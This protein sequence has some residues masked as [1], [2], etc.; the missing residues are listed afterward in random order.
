MSSNTT[1]VQIAKA[2]IQTIMKNFYNSK[3]IG[4]ATL[5]NKKIVFLFFLNLHNPRAYDLPN[6][7]I[8]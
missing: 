5:I 3:H 2:W 1:E 6:K 4:C 7:E 8:I